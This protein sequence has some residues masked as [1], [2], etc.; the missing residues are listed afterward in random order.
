MP[1][2]WAGTHAYAAP[3]IVAVSTED[4]VRHAVAAGGPV[5]ALGTRHSFTDLPDTSGTLIDV[6]GLDGGF[7]LDRGDG[8]V[9]VDVAAGTRYGVLAQWL[10]AEGWALHNLGS[11]P[12]IS[13]AGATATATHGSGDRNGV[14]TT[15]VRGIRFVGADAEVHDVHRGDPDFPALAAGVGAFGVVTRLTLAVQPSYRMRQDVYKGVSWDAALADFR[16]ITGAG[17]SVSVFTRWDEGGIGDVWVKTRLDADDDAVPDELLDGARDVTANP[18]EDLPDITELGGVPGPWMLR[19]PHFRLDGQPSFGDEIQSEYFVARADAPAALNAMRALAPLIQP[20]LLVSELRTA[21]SD[22][23]WLSGAYARDMLAIHF[24]WRN[25]PA[26]VL[27]VL[28]RIEEAL[29][30]LGARPHWG[31][32][33]TFDAAAIARVHPRL[34]DARAVFER[35][36]PEGRFANAHLQRLGVRA[37]R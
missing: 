22:D 24:T 27:G 3:R 10:D 11:L 6:S 4:D 28:P 36:D 29:A 19:L 35:L 2:N 26:G 33:H 32:L 37:E 14:L 21:A 9:T 25:D 16:A 1:Q 5:H 12:H 7:S 18:L 31:K 13:V 8:G 15:A 20:H 30:P 34:V 23:L 17:Y